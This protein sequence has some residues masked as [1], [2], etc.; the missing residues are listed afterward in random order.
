MSGWFH[1]VAY[2][3]D[4]VR[5]FMYDYLDDSLPTVTSIRFH[6]HLNGCPECRE[7]LFLYKKA[8]DA[9]SFRKEHPAPDAF[10][11][12]TLEF[13]EKEGVVAPEDGP[14]DRQPK[15]KEPA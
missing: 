10:L 8:A 12:S 14:E 5:D 2:P 4:R 1:K 15:G 13:L 9:K 3:C 6:M 11:A 7:Y